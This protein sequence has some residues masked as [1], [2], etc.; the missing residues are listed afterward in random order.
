MVWEAEIYY[1]TAIK[2][3]NPALELLTGDTIDISE[4]LEFEL[5]NLVWFWN[6]HPDDTKPMLGKWLGILHSVGI[7][8]CYW[9]PN[10]KGKVISYTTIQNLSAE[11]PR[12]PNIQESISDYHN[13][14]EAALGS[15]DFG[16]ILYVCDSFINDYEC[17]TA[18]VTLM[19]NNTKDCH[20]HLRHMT[21]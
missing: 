2:Y 3:G 4:C 10:E 14:L 5:Y 9:I 13:S 20:I 18:K 8:I 7:M 11:K 6:N 21:S 15:G 1:H 12:Y 16:T 17:V 19:R